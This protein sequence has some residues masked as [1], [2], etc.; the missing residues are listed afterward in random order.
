MRRRDLR[1]ASGIGLVMLRLLGVF[2]S[3]STPN[4]KVLPFMKFQNVMCITF[5][6]NAEFYA[7]LMHSKFLGRVG[8]FPNDLC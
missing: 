1:G 3:R 8:D 6:C 4:G 7:D 2:K 5:G